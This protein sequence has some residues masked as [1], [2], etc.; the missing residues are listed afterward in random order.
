MYDCMFWVLDEGSWKIKFVKRELMI[1]KQLPEMQHL[2]PWRERQG[3]GTTPQEDSS[4]TR[5]KSDGLHY[6]KLNARISI[7]DDTGRD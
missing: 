3:C 4:Q 6:V 7:E 5:G 1:W 2:T